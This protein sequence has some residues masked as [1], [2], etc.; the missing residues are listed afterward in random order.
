K[1]EQRLAS[2]AVAID[3][4]HVL[5]RYKTWYLP[6]AFG[7]RQ[8]VQR[9]SIKP[10]SVDSVVRFGFLLPYRPC[11]LL[12]HDW[13]FVDA[14]YLPLV[15]DAIVL[16]LPPLQFGLRDDTAKGIPRGLCFFAGRHR[17]K[18]QYTHL[19]L[20]S[21]DVPFFKFGLGSGGQL[22]DAKTFQAIIVLRLF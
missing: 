13:H 8:A 7:H 17:G 6:L 4:R 10:A 9:G 14:R 2:A 15:Q 1:R 12:S 20:D 21:F 19:F 3:Q 22:S 11:L 18:R 16:R 5:G